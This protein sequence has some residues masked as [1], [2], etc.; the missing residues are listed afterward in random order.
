MVRAST[1]IVPFLALLSVGAPSRQSVADVGGTMSIE[2]RS[3]F[4]ILELRIHA[5]TSY[6]DAPNLLSG[7]LEVG[8]TISEPNDGPTY[9]TVIREWYSGGP[10]VALTTASP[11]DAGGGKLIV[12]DE[13]F[14]LVLP[15]PPDSGSE[16][17]CL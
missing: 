3:Q 14:R 1:R 2:N 13:S 16:G 17:G 8:E 7:P 15:P 11:V 4:R 12:F 10:P 6:L 5:G 9:V